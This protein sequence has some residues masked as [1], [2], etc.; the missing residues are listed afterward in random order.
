MPRWQE[1][2]PDWFRAAVAA[3]PERGGV[4]VEGADIELLAW[5]ERGRP[6]L[7]LLHGK[8]GHAEWWRFIAPFF[9]DRWRVVAPSW[10][11]QGRSGWR[12]RYSLTQCAREALAA[13]EAGGLNE[14]GPP[15]VVG[16][17]FG[18]FPALH[19]GTRHADR[20]RGVVAVDAPIRPGEGWPGPPKRGVADTVYASEDEAAGRFRFVPPLH[21]AQPAITDFI[22]RQ[23]LRPVTRPDGT[24]GWSW[25][26]DPHG[27]QHFDMDTGPMNHRGV[28]APLALV[29]G[30]KSGLIDPAMWASM[31]EEAP[32]GTVCVAIPEANHHVMAD[33]PLAFVTALRTLL[34]AWSQD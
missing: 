13:A 26:F 20:V 31:Q 34:A 12:E 14:A 19:L 18:A 11:G 17:S 23:S 29:W 25:R 7:L 1:A 10:S 27:W 2:A 28:T 15:V 8:G 22:A 9:A 16:H 21:T 33:Q 5:G 30:E 3:E 6:G 4:A 32:P 24:P